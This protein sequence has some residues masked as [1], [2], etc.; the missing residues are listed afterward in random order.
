MGFFKKLFGNKEEKQPTA[1]NAAAQAAAALAQQKQNYD[2]LAAA[3]NPTAAV[4]EET[5]L[6][7]FAEY[8]APNKDFYS[9]P[10]SEKFKAYF[11]VVNAARD[12]M[13]AQ[14]QLFTAATKWTA[15]QL[16]DMVNNPK[17]GI[18]NMKICALI[19]LMGQFAVVKDAVYCVDFAGAIPN[20]IALYLLLVAQKQPADKRGQ[21]LDTGEGENT[22]ALSAAIDSLK[23]L[24]PSWSPRI[25]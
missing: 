1:N 23:I 6:K 14:Q 17:P 24:D 2:A 21:V 13:F 16:V 10:G 11:G 15:Q 25:F 7:I 8:F 22:Q 20:C 19:F 3:K 4:P 5:L 9:V 12:E 18:T